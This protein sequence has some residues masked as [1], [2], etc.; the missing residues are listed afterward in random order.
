VGADLLAEAIVLLTMAKLVNSRQ[1][2]RYLVLACLF[3]AVLA[4]VVS[5]ANMLEGGWAPAAWSDTAVC[6]SFVAVYWW[7]LTRTLR[8]NSHV[9]TK[10]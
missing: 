1:Q 6:C 8:T 2:A 7:H 10:R 9:Q 5:V 4:L 3:R